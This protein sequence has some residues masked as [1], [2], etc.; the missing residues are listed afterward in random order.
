MPDDVRDDIA[1]AYAELGR[2]CGQ[3]EPV[4]AVRSSAVGEDSAAT[5]FAGQQE[6]YLWRQ[7]IEDVTT[8]VVRCWDSLYSPQ[9]A[10]YRANRVAGA[11]TP[12][13]SVAVQ[14]MVDAD[15]AGVLFTLSPVT[16][17]R[18]VIAINAAWGLGEG[19]VGGHITPDEYWVDKVSMRVKSRTI[20]DKPRQVKPDRSRGGTAEVDVPAERREQA[21][22][23]DL[24]VLELAQLGKVVEQHYR[25]PQD[26]EWAIADGVISVLQSR[27]ETVWTQRRQQNVETPT[28]G[29]SAVDVVLRTMG[30]RPPSPPSPP[31][32]RSAS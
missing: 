24:E 7:G 9:A 29:P 14:Q 5:S 13:M 20:V 11:E 21:C 16:G 23:S 1:R 3:V 26:V 30:V 28:G 15:V 25:T 8:C 2:R 31:S 18:S 22:L 12:R 6:T 27:P 19:V 4:V 10:A 32:P 17:D